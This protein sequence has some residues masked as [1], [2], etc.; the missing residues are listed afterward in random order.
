MGMSLHGRDG[1]GVVEGGWLG[2]A[3][4]QEPEWAMEGTDARMW[5]REWL[6]H[7]VKEMNGGLGSGVSTRED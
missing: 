1:G 7:V 3:S 6:S 5:G 2:S 4:N